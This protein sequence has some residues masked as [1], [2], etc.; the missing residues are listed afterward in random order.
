MSAVPIAAAAKN[1]QNMF[2]P[3]ENRSRETEMTNGADEWCDAYIFI[4]P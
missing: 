1:S 2:A 4:D 3:V